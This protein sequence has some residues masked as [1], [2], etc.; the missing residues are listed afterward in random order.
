MDTLYILYSMLFFFSI[1]LTLVLHFYLSKPKC[2]YIS[3]GEEV[4]GN[5]AVPEGKDAMSIFS[6]APKF[7]ESAVCESSMHNSGAADT[8]IECCLVPA[9]ELAQD[10]SGG[11]ANPPLTREKDLIVLITDLENIFGEEE[12]DLGV[13]DCSEH[14]QHK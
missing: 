6:S 8:L 3:K 4:N 14:Q 9:E 2:V 13:S 5:S 10:E 7:G 12:D 11:K 1:E